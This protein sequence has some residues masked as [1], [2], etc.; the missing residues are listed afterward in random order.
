MEQPT[1]S[2]K[3]A[4]AIAEIADELIERQETRQDNAE[5]AIAEV[6]DE[7]IRRIGAKERIQPVVGGPLPP[8]DP[9]I[10]E[11]DIDRANARFDDLLPEFA[12][13][14]S[15][16]A[17]GRKAKESTPNKFVWEAGDLVIDKEKGSA[18]SGNWLHSSF[19][20]VG[21]GRGGSDPAGTGGSLG[22]LGLD[23]DATVE[24][25]RQASAQRREGQGEDKPSPK[26]LPDPEEMGR[27]Q[28]EVDQI[29]DRTSQSTSKNEVFGRQFYSSWNYN[30][31]DEERLA[32]RAYAGSGYGNMNR[33]LRGNDPIRHDAN[34]P[35]DTEADIRKRI[36]IVRGAL[37]RGEVPHDMNVV[38]GVSSDLMPQIRDLPVGGTFVDKGFTS[39]SM[40]NMNWQGPG[41]N[42]HIFVP[43]GTK[44]GFLGVETWQLSGM[45]YESEMLLPPGSRFMVLDKA[46]NG[47]VYVGLVNQGE[48][49]FFDKGSA[50][51]GNWLHT[52][53]NRME[54][55]RGGSD[56]SGTGGSGL[57]IMGLDADSTPEE[58][59]AASE[60]IRQARDKY[61]VGKPPE[62]DN[63][64]KERMADLHEKAVGWPPTTE[65]Q[66][67][68]KRILVDDLAQRAG[69]DPDDVDTMLGVW[70]A[71]SNDHSMTALTT[72]QVV[73]EEMGVPM[74]AFSR[75]RLEEVERRRETTIV[76][77]MA[78]QQVDREQAAKY[79][80]PRYT[81][82]VPEDRMRK[83]AHAM[84]EKTQ[85][86]MR[87][88]GYKPGDMVRLYR[89][90]SLEKG[91]PS[92][93]FRVG[94]IV[95]I[96][97]NAAGSWTTGAFMAHGFA[98]PAKGWNGIVFSLDVPVER[99]F[100]TFVSGLGSIMENELVI[101]GGFPGD[102]AQVEK[103]RPATK[104]LD[105][106]IERAKALFDNLL[107]G[108]HGELDL[109]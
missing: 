39:T 29:V 6:A 95:P 53:F 82:R 81:L 85:E 84:Y 2:P 100:S 13:L 47:D 4:E 79:V 38:R 103:V 5:Q 48:K 55:G 58:R 35:D 52:S 15:A 83:V 77:V 107:S 46:P 64:T 17:S 56:P 12:G 3:L 31:S 109:E 63:P 99:V 45:P 105:G 23:P 16:R 30:L 19:N 40:H 50:A 89:G 49:A 96:I 66:V 97:G 43:K 42:I 73:A 57:A 69:V 92:D 72:Q 14:L 37:D 10:T 102:L 93:N 90:V 68:T 27:R 60:K 86:T 61:G 88:A 22:K 18:A 11:E 71:T 78:E 65:K 9:T 44:A 8:A 106:L 20:R 41:N 67:A 33:V 104:G 36:G 59:R 91:G 62:G 80:N 21:V 98:K 108:A 101:L 94:D 28:R 70:M 1:T 26:K 54:V 75:K 76:Q 87:E 24:E 32:I 34:R 51:S 74:S 25:R 7:L